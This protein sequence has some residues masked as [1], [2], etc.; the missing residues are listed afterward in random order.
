MKPSNEADKTLGIHRSTRLLDA[1]RRRLREIHH[2]RIAIH[3]T[4][5]IQLITFILIVWSIGKY[6]LK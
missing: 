1:P 4:E 3:I 5:S 6:I 2:N